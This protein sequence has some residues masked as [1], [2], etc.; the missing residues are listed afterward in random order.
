MGYL[1][2]GEIIPEK[3]NIELNSDKEVKTITVSNS[4]DRPIQVGY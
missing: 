3:G 2:P 1:I 4:G